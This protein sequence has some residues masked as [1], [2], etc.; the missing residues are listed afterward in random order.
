MLTTDRKDDDLSTISLG[1]PGCSEYT[2][3]CTALGAALM[4][5]DIG[6]FQHTSGAFW[7]GS[8]GTAALELVHW[9]SCP[10]LCT[11]IHPCDHASTHQGHSGERQRTML[12]WIWSTDCHTPFREHAHTLVI[13]HAHMLGILVS[14]RE[15]CCLGVGPLTV[16][17]PCAQSHILVT[18]QAHVRAN[19]VRLKWHCCLEFGSSAVI[20]HSV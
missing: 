8:N 6:Q 9:L 3:R 10:T 13:L 5:K 2:P 4:S 16:L 15:P 20:A 12:P 1:L 7:F 11:I 18:M 14:V 19:L 17:P